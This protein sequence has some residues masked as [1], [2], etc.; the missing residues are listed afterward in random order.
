[1]TLLRKIRRALHIPHP[2]PV[3]GCQYW[4]SLNASLVE[5]LELERYLA[6]HER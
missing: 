6:E 3:Q 4:D 5:Q 2:A 1:M